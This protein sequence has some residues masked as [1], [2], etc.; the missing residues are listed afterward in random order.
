MKQLRAENVQLQQQLALLAAQMAQLQAHAAPPPHR[1]CP[2]AVPDK[3]DGNQ[4]MFPAFLGQCHFFISLRAED[5]PTDWDKV[6]FMISLLSGSAARW[7]TPLL[8]QASP[9]LDNFRGFCDYLRFL[10]EDPIKT[11]TATQR[12]KTLKQ[13]WQPL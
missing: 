12:L 11:Q 8:V 4:A 2:V 3:F 1:K 13:G 7:A 9:L 10:Y 6:G 5:F